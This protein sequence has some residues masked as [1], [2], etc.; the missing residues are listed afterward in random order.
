MTEFYQIQIWQIPDFF[1]A[2]EDF[3]EK[4][5]IERWVQW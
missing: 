2:K 3:I 5:A 1:P 4:S